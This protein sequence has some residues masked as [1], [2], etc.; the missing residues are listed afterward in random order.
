[1]IG[2]TEVNLNQ[3]DK[4]IRPKLKDLEPLK[5]SPGKTLRNL[6]SSTKYSKSKLLDVNRINNY[7]SKHDKLDISQRDLDY[8]A[9]SSQRDKNSHLGSKSV[10]AF[11]RNQGQK[12]PNQI[13]TEEQSVIIPPSERSNA[14]L[15]QYHQSH[16]SATLYSYSSKRSTND[17]SRYS[18]KLIPQ[19]PT[20]RVPLV[21]HGNIRF[22]SDTKSNIKKKLLE[23][24]GYAIVPDRWSPSGWKFA[25]VDPLKTKYFQNPNRQNTH[26]WIPTKSALF[27]RTSSTNQFPDM[28]SQMT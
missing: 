5:H 16:K 28:R 20:A 27:D 1:M 7:F 21:N 25:Y 10:S 26:G 12:A 9:M 24:D 3:T 14:M 4:K 13:K 17:R 23:S 11:S 19:S 22:G 8:L 2:V 6:G 15:S 18:H